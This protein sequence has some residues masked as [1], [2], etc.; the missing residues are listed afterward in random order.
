MPTEPANEAYTDAEYVAILTQERHMY[1]WTLVTFGAF[2]TE[3]AESHALQHYPYDPV[4]Q[5][6]PFLFHERAW[7]YAMIELHGSTFWTTKPEILHAPAAYF[8]EEERFRA[9][10]SDDRPVL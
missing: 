4:G 9:G 2:R 3:D 1:A 7:H 6:N 10:S 8:E 5:N